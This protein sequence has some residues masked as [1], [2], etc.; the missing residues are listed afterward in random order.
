M[1]RSDGAGGPVLPVETGHADEICRSTSTSSSGI[2]VIM[3]TGRILR[4]V[5]FGMRPGPGQRPAGSH[6]L[7]ERNH[8]K[9]KTNDLVRLSLDRDDL[10]HDRTLQGAT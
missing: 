8:N 5:N 3:P 7:R 9:V 4:P 1:D 2:Q 10:P 6:A